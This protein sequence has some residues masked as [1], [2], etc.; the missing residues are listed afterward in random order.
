[1]I[2]RLLPLLLAGA[3]SALPAPRVALRAVRAGTPLLARPA[4]RPAAF[5]ELP[6]APAPG[7]EAP[8]AAPDVL[9]PLDPVSARLAEVTG[10]AAETLLQAGDP[11]RAEDDRAQGDREAMAALFTGERSHAPAGLP[12]LGPA[13]PLP[14]KAVSASGAIITPRSVE[15]GVA[16]GLQPAAA[17]LD[18]RTPGY[19]DARYWL[20]HV[21]QRRDAGLAVAAGLERAAAASS[22]KL[23]ALQ[24]TQLAA[25][26][27]AAPQDG[28][29]GLQY[30]RRVAEEQDAA[31]RRV[32]ERVRALPLVAAGLPTSD[33]LDTFE[34]GLVRGLEAAAAAL[35]VHA[36]GWGNAPFWIHHFEMRRDLADAVGAALAA[37]AREAGHKAL[38][39]ALEKIAADVR[40]LPRKG[41][42]D[43]RYWVAM[44]RRQD[45][46]LSGL[47][48][49]IR[50]LA[51]LS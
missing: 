35:G 47:V 51:K 9:A 45:E 32:A 26:L 12:V 2:G 22:S 46:L 36:D 28:R 49:L 38:T 6:A 50:D 10:G 8:Q 25:D 21:E 39:P 7:V 48:R 23:F 13:S 5:S 41:Y 42:G 14:A 15:E 34:T 17:A 18:V 33:P 16:A 27:R 24:L 19:G 3:A 29:G 44:V 37:L 11:A 20:H 1:M 31:Y 30:W 4:A 40:T 43:V